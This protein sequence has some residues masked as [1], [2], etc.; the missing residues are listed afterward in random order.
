M[1]LIEM[2]IRVAIVATTISLVAIGTYLVHWLLNAQEW[3][4]IYIRRERPDLLRKRQER[5][6]K[7]VAIKRVL[8]RRKMVAR[9]VVVRDRIIEFLAKD[10]PQ[11]APIFIYIIMSSL[12]VLS[13]FALVVLGYVWSTL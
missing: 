2:L 7:R 8:K 5:T 4:D 6:G 12:L 1:I 9:A 3:V 13:L 11:T 10:K